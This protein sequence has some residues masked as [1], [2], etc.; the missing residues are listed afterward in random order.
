M[1]V[2]APERRLRYPGS[3]PFRDS[4]V[5]R[6]LFFGRDQDAEQVLHSILS[7]D[8]FVLY[9]RSGVGKTSL[10]Q[11]LVTKGLEQRDLWPVFVRLDDV[12]ATPTDLVRAALT[13]LEAVDELEITGHDDPTD[14]L[15]GMLA[16]LR[17]WRGDVLQLPV[18]VFD[19]FEELFTLWDGTPER[20]ERRRSFVEQLTDVARGERARTRGDEPSALRPRVKIVLSLREEFLGELDVFSEHIPAVLRHRQRLEQ[21]TADQARAAIVRPAELDDDE[22]ELESPPFTYEEAAIERVMADLSGT[23]A[24]PERGRTGGAIEASQLQIVCRFV[25]TEIVLRGRASGNGDITVTEDDLEAAGGPS[26]ILKSFYE[27][28]LQAFDHGSTRRRVRRLCE[29]G[30]ISGGRRTSLDDVQIETRFGLDRDVLGELV[31]RRLL[32][33]ETR[34]DRSYYELAHDSL[35]E[36]LTNYRRE[37]AAHQRRRW[38]A[39]GVGIAVIAVIGAIVFWERARSDAAADAAA[40]RDAAEAAQSQVSVAQAAVVEAQEELGVA[41]AQLEESIDRDLAVGDSWSG[42]EIVSAGD[43]ERIRFRGDEGSG[44]TVQV[45]PRAPGLDAAI[46]LLD[47]DRSPIAQIDVSGPGSV[48][49]IAVILPTDGPYLVEVRG[50]NGTDGSYTATI[51]SSPPLLPDD[52]QDRSIS[53]PDEWDYVPFVG[54]AGEPITVRVEPDGDLDPTFEIIGPGGAQIARAARAS[55]GVAEVAT[56]L[57]PSD[58]TYAVRVRGAQETTGPYTITRRPARELVDGRA[59]TAAVDEADVGRFPFAGTAGTA[60]TV[61]LAPTTGSFDGVLEI[62]DPSGARIDR[63]DSAG[64]G[65]EETLTVILSDDATYVVT[66]RE[67]AAEPGEFEIRADTSA[68]AELDDDGRA[69][70]ELEPVG[71]F[72]FDGAFDDLVTITLVPV[73]DFDP[74]FDVLGP[75]GDRL[76]RVDDHGSGEGETFTFP[77]EDERPHHVVARS[78][79]A[80][81][82]TYELDVVTRRTPLVPDQVLEGDI[83]STGDVDVFEFTGRTDDVVELV[84][85]PS[86]GTVLDAQLSLADAGGAEIAAADDTGPSGSETILTVLPRGGQYVA[87]VR[88]FT[89]STGAYTLRLARPDVEEIEIGR[90]DAA[91]AAPVRGVISDPDEISVHRFVATEAGGFAVITLD[92]APGSAFAGRFDVLGP[93]P[94]HA[95]IAGGAVG[96]DGGAQARVSLPKEGDYHVVV[97]APEDSIGEFELSVTEPDVDT[98]EL[99]GTIGGEIATANEVD[100]YLFNATSGTAITLTVQPNGQLD[101]AVDLFVRDTG[102]QV[103]VGNSDAGPGAPESL[104]VE[105]PADG[106]Y[107]VYVQGADGSVGGYD[108]TLS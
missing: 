85:R 18:L 40:A 57:L 55:A 3:P 42:G 107:V 92:A 59:V 33:A 83:D 103:N 35:I 13:D 43:V 56:L 80:T 48:E 66:V 45:R 102:A 7:H 21:L 87:K 67:S 90:R 11:T 2:A 81:A 60:V 50:T 99:G 5:D 30:L 61:T 4:D 12:R 44:I 26:T 58:G 96:A 17:I 38:V 105:L 9:A 19:Q 53:A 36:P 1:S 63:V 70:G 71:V 74:A 6:R 28:E 14:D 88:G 73:G 15:Y 27:R 79:R 20:I 89:D 24:D 16:R 94:A 22:L 64:E 101:A 104:S 23:G 76:A 29:T 52:G 98:I 75:E 47:P 8:L 34:V 62:L 106:S 68:I 77:L 10:L 54:G 69:S 108:L 41:E 100:T 91:A 32:R 46:T 82:G 31:D 49:T 78:F 84:L 37:R 72:S 25:E 39:A 95:V 65:D 97:R 86:A 93:A 51:H